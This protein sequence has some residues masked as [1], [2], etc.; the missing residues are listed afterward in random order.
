[1]RKKLFIQFYRYCIIIIVNKH[2]IFIYNSRSRND[3]L[4]EFQRLIGA[5][6]IFERFCNKL[7][8]N[9][10]ESHTFYWIQSNFE[11]YLAN[12]YQESQV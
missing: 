12:W 3:L 1:M 8:I 9:I 4:P 2:I 5:I 7:Q 6:F 10:G 11:K